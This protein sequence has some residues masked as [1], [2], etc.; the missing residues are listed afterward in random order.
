MKPQTI[1]KFQTT[2]SEIII[3]NLKTHVK[4]TGYSINHMKFVMLG[5]NKMFH[6]EGT[7]VFEIGT[8]LKYYFDEPQDMIIK[9]IDFGKGEIIFKL[10]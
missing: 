3:E 9:D 2:H 6:Q 1:C 10:Q 8:N 5:E 7:P 4:L